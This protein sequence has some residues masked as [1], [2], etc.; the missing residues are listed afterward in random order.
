MQAS[1]R[2]GQVSSSSLA[3][4]PLP[5]S[6][7]VFPQRV[8]MCFPWS[9]GSLLVLCSLQF[10]ASQYPFNKPLFCLTHSGTAKNLKLNVIGAPSFQRKK[11]KFKAVSYSLWKWAWLLEYGLYRIIHCNLEHDAKCS[12]FLRILMCHIMRFQSTTD[13]LYDGG[14]I[15]LPWSWK[16]RIASDVIAFIK[17]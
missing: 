16:I 15:K 1:D 12:F 7:Q 5:L 3:C 10:W 2:R 13:Y 17:S 9:L 6:H 14:P 8:P 11:V 4:V